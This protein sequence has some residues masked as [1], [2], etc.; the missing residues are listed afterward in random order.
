MSRTLKMVMMTCTMVA[1][2]PALAVD[3]AR[4]QAMTRHQVIVQTIGCM[5]RRM[6]ADKSISYNE[7]AKVCKNQIVKQRDNATAGVLVASDVPATR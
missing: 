1:G 4:P 6:S 3:S 7:A 5:R 2:V